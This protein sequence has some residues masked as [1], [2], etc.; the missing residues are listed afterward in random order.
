MTTPPTTTRQR[1]IDPDTAQTAPWE[2]KPSRRTRPAKEPISTVNQEP[3]VEDNEPAEDVVPQVSMGRDAVREARKNAQDSNSRF[4]RWSENEQIVRFM[5]EG[6]FSYESRW[7]KRQGRQSFPFLGEGDPLE[8]IGVKKSTRIVYPIVN[9]SQGE[10]TVQSL[11]VTVTIDGILEGHD[12]NPKTGPLSR[13]YWSLSRTPSQQKGAGGM[14]KYNYHIQMVKAR[15]LEEDWGIDEDAA[16]E[17][18]QSSEAL[19]P[20]EVLGKVSIHELQQ[21][22]DEIMGLG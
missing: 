21:I 5:D 3:E 18:Y 22:A 1:R 15:D 10:P 17:F 4:F 8:A 9:F 20:T 19:T 14:T 7:V 6:L 16:E 12:A 2:E 11:E 13:H